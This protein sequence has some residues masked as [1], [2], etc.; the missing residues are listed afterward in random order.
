E[1]KIKPQP[2][3]P[4]QTV[5]FVI[6]PRYMNVDIRF[7]VDVTQGGLDFYM[8]PT[9][10]SFIVQTNASTGHHD[11]LLDSSYV[12]FHDLLDPAHSPA[13]E[14]YPLN[15]QPAGGPLAS[16]KNTPVCGGNQNEGFY[17]TDRTAKDLI[18]YVT[19]RQCKSLLRVFGLKNRLVVTLPHTVHA[20]GQT[21]FYIALRAR[22][23]PSASYGLVFFRQDQLHIHLFVFFSVFFSC[24]FLFLAICVLAWKAKQA[25]DMR[26][27]RRRHVVEMLHMAKRPFGRVN[28]SLDSTPDINA[29]PT[30]AP[31]RRRTRGL[32]HSSSSSSAAASALQ[33]QL[34][35]HQ[36]QNPLH[37]PDVAP[38]A[39]EPTVDNYAAV[40][41]VFVRLPGKQKSQITLAL[42][43]SLIM[44]GRSSSYPSYSRVQYRRRSSPGHGAGC[45][46]QNL[47]QQLQPLQPASHASP[48]HH[49]H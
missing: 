30:P 22:P 5:F 16:E 31:Q 36:L 17:V 43:S 34:L 33:H 9:H 38:I 39:L 21:K 48:R 19:L 8:S 14:L 1:C 49:A 11:I 37:Q 18:T 6:Q 26:R 27:A 12:W 44:M 2:L 41:T 40:G 25:A 15:I 10:E 28:L 13:D 35:L 20:L 45:H 47:Q 46:G 4:G 7:I 24:F 32:K 29:L 23:G 3:K 42:A